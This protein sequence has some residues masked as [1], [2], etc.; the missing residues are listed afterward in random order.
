MTI[1]ETST[2]PARRP[3]VVTFIGVILYIQA[4]LAAIAGISLLIWR[5][6]IRDWLEQEGAP[7]SNGGLTGTIIG[8]FIAAAL[9]LLAAAGLMRGSSGWRLVVAIVQGIAMAFAVYTLIAH[10]VGGLV[11]RSVFTLFIGAFVLWALYAN[12]E[13]DRYFEQNG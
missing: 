9:A 8:E 1:T 10:H 7:L 6:D 5:N 11:Y 13:S 4:A 3:G 12:D 2:T